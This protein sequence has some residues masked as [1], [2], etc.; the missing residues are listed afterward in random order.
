MARVAVILPAHN[1]EGSVTSVV[2]GFRRAGARVIVVDNGS[3][4]ETAARAR[5]A[6]A[7]VVSEP[8]LGYGSACLRGIEHLRE[9]PPEVVAF[10]D[11]DGTQD[12]QELG[13]L[14]EPILRGEAD[15]MLG[16][17]KH[18]EP[19]AMPWHQR[20]GNAAILLYLRQRHRARIRDVPPF[21]A[22]R[23]DALFALGL[24]ETTYGLPV[25][26]VARALGRGF[27]VAEVD[28]SYLR[29][30]AGKSKV[31][32]SLQ[33]SLRA[34][35]VMLRAI[36]EAS[37]DSRSRFGTVVVFARAPEPGRVK[38]RL[39]KRYEPTWVL[40]LYRAM[41]E[42]TLRSA[43]LANANVI[44]SHTPSE[45]FSEQSLADALIVQ[46]GDSFGTRFDDA[47]RQA[48][49][50]YPDGP[51]LIVGADTPH[52]PLGIVVDALKA[53]QDGKVV[54]GPAPRGGF[55]LLGFPREPF[56]VDAAFASADQVGELEAIAAANHLESHR[57]PAW[58]DIDEPDDVERVARREFSR[59]ASV[60]LATERFLKASRS[61]APNAVADVAG[62]KQLAS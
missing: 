12:P 44:L 31:T 42:D 50:S 22:I 7:E 23:A 25:E 51:L 26:T 37:R 61:L 11:C 53:A 6:L 48:R 55:Y 56:A 60:L 38:T 15:L 17:R 36:N 34:G 4:D 57:L 30:T 33:K 3:T 39:M 47:L 32:G 18:I 10:A 1:E 9:D 52:L 58:F 5:A 14:T 24:R 41:L 62:S 19:G 49:Q 40:G 45:P 21:R 20:V 46:R 27:R 29:R 16:R 28:V 13:R 59:K 54:I 35:A 2:E 8:R 43:R